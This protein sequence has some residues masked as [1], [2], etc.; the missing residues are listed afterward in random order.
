MIEAWLEAQALWLFAAIDEERTAIKDFA[1]LWSLFEAYAWRSGC[2]DRILTKVTSLHA[3]GVLDVAPFA[4]PMG[5]FFQ[6]YY[7]GT[8]LTPH[9]P[10]LHLRKGDKQSWS[11]KCCAAM[12]PTMP[13]DYPSCSS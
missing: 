13:A 5:Y 1:L 6:R 8:D 7:D 2:A 4:A 11:S 10:H 9:Y 12:S 3:E